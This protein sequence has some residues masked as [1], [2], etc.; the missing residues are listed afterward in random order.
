VTDHGP[1]HGGLCSSFGQTL[2]T[3]LLSHGSTGPT[4]MLA[5]S[6][7]AA[8]RLYSSSLLTCTPRRSQSTW[9]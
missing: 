8:K 2:C 1:A 9:R 6:L 4:V 3:S 7:D 5:L